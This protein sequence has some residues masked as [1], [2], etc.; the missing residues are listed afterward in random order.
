MRFNSTL[1]NYSDTPDSRRTME[2]AGGG[3]VV[4]PPLLK[5]GPFLV[6]VHHALIKDCRKI[7]TKKGVDLLVTEVW[8][9]FADN[10]CRSIVTFQENKAKQFA[11]CIR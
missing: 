4:K 3:D 10:R 6:S 11:H 8:G 7:V 2:S 9:T 1:R 5:V